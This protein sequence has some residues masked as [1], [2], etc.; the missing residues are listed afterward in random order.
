[1]QVAPLRGQAPGLVAVVFARNALAPDVVAA[2]PL[3]PGP[4]VIEQVFVSVG[5][6]GFA[7]RLWP[8]VFQAPIRPAEGA[9]FSGFVAAGRRVLAVRGAGSGEAPL[10]GISR[11]NH[12]GVWWPRT[13][14]EW[15]SWAPGLVGRDL[16]AP[17]P[18]DVA[19]WYVVR[20]LG[21]A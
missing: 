17:G 21:P 13:L 2:G 1:M 16:P 20:F 14:I 11:A 8:L 15:A 10:W 9:D 5:S 19:A 18:L 4:A 12:G 7:V 3:L 6:G